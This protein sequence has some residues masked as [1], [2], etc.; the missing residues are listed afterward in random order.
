MF[1]DLRAKKDWSKKAIYFIILDHL[2]LLFVTGYHCLSQGGGTAHREAH[3]KKWDGNMRPLKTDPC[4]P[5]GL[6]F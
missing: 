3:A 4:G 2:R 5:D 1:R 6:F